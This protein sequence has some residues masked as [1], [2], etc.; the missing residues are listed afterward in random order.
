MRGKIPEKESDGS[1]G[2]KRNRQG[3]A[4]NVSHKIHFLS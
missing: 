4:F 3:R 1:G 2:E